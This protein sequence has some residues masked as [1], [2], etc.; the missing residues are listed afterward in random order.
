MMNQNN[1]TSLIRGGSDT[2]TVVSVVPVMVGREIACT[3]PGCRFTY[4]DAHRIPSGLC[5]ICR[6]PDDKDRS[7]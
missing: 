4:G 3:N 6:I 5:P 1:S 7:S 2:L